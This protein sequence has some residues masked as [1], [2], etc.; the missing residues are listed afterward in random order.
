[1]CGAGVFR[2]AGAMNKVRAAIKMG[3]GLDKQTLE[4]VRGKHAHIIVGRVSY[5]V[6]GVWGYGEQYAPNMS[7]TPYLLCETGTDVKEGDILRGRNKAWQIGAVTV[8][9]LL[10]G[11]VCIQAQ[12][13]EI[14][15]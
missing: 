7:T 4:V 13:T 15:E 6:G 12:L 3:I 11:D 10:G 1:M 8:P 2:W 9:T 14:E 5:Q